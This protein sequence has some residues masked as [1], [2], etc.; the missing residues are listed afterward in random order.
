MVG[1][2]LN[3]DRPGSDFTSFQPGSA[4]ALSCQAACYTDNR[5][6]A[7]TYLKPNI[8]G[9]GRNGKCWLKDSAPPARA[10]KCCVSGV[11]GKRLGPKPTQAPGKVIK[12]RGSAKAK[13]DVDV[14]SG[15][16]GRFDIICMMRAGEKGVALEH[17][18]DGWCKLEL[19][20]P[21]G[22]GWVADDHL[23]K[24]PAGDN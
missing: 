8:N 17:H 21:G 15:P 7:W 12:A 11:A 19:D 16:G 3:T 1:V 22:V 2:S 14:Y 5:C 4:D 24:C 9:S 6:K 20:V 13:N 10:D 18:P 23:N